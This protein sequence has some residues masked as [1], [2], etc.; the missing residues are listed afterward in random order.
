MVEGIS[1]GVGLLGCDGD[2][3]D[4]W[5]ALEGVAETSVEDPFCARGREI[6]DTEPGGCSPLPFG[7]VFGSSGEDTLMEGVPIA[8]GDPL[9]AA[10]EKPDG[11]C[12][13]GLG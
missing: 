12:S 11:G 13:L 6:P 9:P 5:G 10:R 3:D 2:G 4:E 7:A 8:G 1:R